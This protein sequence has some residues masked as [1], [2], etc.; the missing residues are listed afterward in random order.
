MTIETPALRSFLLDLSKVLEVVLEDEQFIRPD[1]AETIDT[2][3]DGILLVERHMYRRHGARKRAPTKSV[4]VTPGLLR[5]IR[6][7]A[8][9]YPHLTQHEIGT[10]FKVNSGRVNE[11]INGKLPHR[12]IR[13]P[14]VTRALEKAKQPNL[15]IST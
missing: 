3:R 5:E 15:D 12:I 14:G 10:I 1:I 13:R 11:A 6:H 9:Q 8:F 7:Y 4:S 2:V